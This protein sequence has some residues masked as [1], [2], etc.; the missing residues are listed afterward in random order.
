MK[1]IA[2]LVSALLLAAMAAPADASKSTRKQK[3]HTSG[4]TKQVKAP[5][6]EV[7]TQSDYIERDV[8]KLPFGTSVW[9][10]QM[11]RENRLTCCN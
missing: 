3:R 7:N 4:H 6:T 5:K 9:W 8:N 2:C 10:D 1:A 11:L